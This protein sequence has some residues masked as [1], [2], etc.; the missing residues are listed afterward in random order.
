MGEAG[1]SEP[2]DRLDPEPAARAGRRRRCRRATATS[3]AGT[4]GTKRSTPTSR[5]AASRARPRAS[6]SDVSGTL[7]AMRERDCGR[8]ALG[9][10]DAEQ[11]RELVEH[12][13]EPD[14]RLEADEHRLG[15]E[16][17]DEA[18]PQQR[19]Q[20]RGGRRPAASASPTAASSA[21]RSPPGTTCASRVPARIAIVV[22]VLTLSTREV[23]SD[24]VDEHRHEDGVEADLDRKARDRRV[25][26]RLGDHDGGGRQ[27]RD[28]V[29]PQPL[30]AGIRASSPA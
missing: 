30:R 3:G 1:R 14:P 7:S 26:H 15:D 4:R 18:E 12:D 19:G 6:R 13:H 25:G 9:E 2:A 20:P 27:A 23:P 24:R 11:L 8:T 5:T 17:G 21:A 29:G 28:H 10:V 22:V 16:V